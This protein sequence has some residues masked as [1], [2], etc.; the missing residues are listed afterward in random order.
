MATLMWVS[1]VYWLY[2]IHEKLY[3][4]VK[5]HNKYKI[6]IMTT[7][8]WTCLLSQKSVDKSL[9]ICEWSALISRIISNYVLV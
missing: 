5:W 3:D 4:D 6:L 1:R 2:I 9:Y 8:G 7:V